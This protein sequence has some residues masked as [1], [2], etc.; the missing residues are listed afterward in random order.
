[1]GFHNSKVW[2]DT[3]PVLILIDDLT[4][5]LIHKIWGSWTL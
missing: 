3:F 4:H 2:I 5:E 1:M